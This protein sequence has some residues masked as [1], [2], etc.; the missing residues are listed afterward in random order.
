MKTF[1]ALFTFQAPRGGNPHPV[2]AFYANGVEIFRV[3]SGMA[4]RREFKTPG[5]SQKATARSIPGG[6]PEMECD[7]P[8]SALVA[9]LLDLFSRFP[10]VSGDH[11][12]LLIVNEDGSHDA[13]LN[14][15]ALGAAY[16]A[17][18]NLTELDQAIAGIVQLADEADAEIA[19]PAHGAISS[20]DSGRLEA[21]RL[22]LCSVG[23]LP[24]HFD[25]PEKAADAVCKMIATFRRELADPPAD[26][27]AAVMRKHG[28][29]GYTEG[30][31]A[32]HRL[33]QIRHG[34]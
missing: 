17:A 5:G 16:S 24:K 8:L 21:L 32:T 4:R 7:R 13:Y 11:S 2:S 34:L 20:D 30:R 12:R 33:V 22:K 31:E 9:R 25:T 3:D 14:G 19:E 6:F 1:S 26:V 27:C 15:V 18:S 29:E 28:V 10:K 23:L